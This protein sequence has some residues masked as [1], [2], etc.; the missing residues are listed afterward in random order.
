MKTLKQELKRR[1]F[2][3][4]GK[5]PEAVVISVCSGDAARARAMIEEFRRLVPDRRHFEIGPQEGGVWRIYLKLRRE[6]R[7]YRI[8]Q[9]AVLFDGDG[10]HRPLRIAACLLAPRRI[11]A[12][13]KGL[14]R[15]HPRLSAWIASWLFLRGVPLDRIFL[16]PWWLC[17]WK[18]DRSVVPTDCRILEGRPVSPLRPRVAVL[19]P[20]FPYPL[21]HGGAVRI[22]HLLR[23]AARRFDIF[24]F[25]FTESGQPLETAPVL[26]FCAR[27]ILVPKP[28]YR[29]PRWSSLSPPEVNE[30]RSPVMRRLLAAAR[31]EH[32][33]ALLQ[34]EYTQLA[35]YGGDILVEHDVTFDLYRQLHEQR[36]TLASWWDL[37]RWRRYERRALRRFRRVVVMSGKDAGM[38][39][40]PHVVAIPNGVDLERFRPAP[41]PEAVGLLFIGSFRHFPNVIAYRFFAEE[42]WPLIRDEFPGMTVTVVAGPGLLTF[43]REATGLA[44][45][46]PDP[47]IRMLEFV[48]DVRPLYEEASLVLVPTLVSA[49][50]NVK[51]LEAMAM[52]RAVVSTSSGCAGLGLTHGA[53]VWIA[54]TPEDFAAG[55]RRLIRDPDL[56]RS[57]AKAAR[58]QAEQHFDWRR[59]GAEQRR[60]W[61]EPRPPGVAVRPA[62]IPDLEEIAAIQAAS[63]EAS[64]WR[65][66]SYLEHRCLVALNGGRVAGFVAWREL[67]EGECE[68]LNLAVAPAL[69]RQGLARTLVRQVLAVSEGPVFLEVRKSNRAAV[70][71]YEGLGFQQIGTRPKYYPHPPE[72][73]IV[74][75]FQSC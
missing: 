29:E 9:A 65:P 34:V 37:A 33:I 71:L 23:E 3:L 64:N 59:L 67:G 26:E 45:P 46:S 57:M 73:G 51:V 5:D 24:L 63:P 39:G 8:G 32:A 4:L 16:R 58:R 62:G 40:A 47:R 19:S 17:P 18:R 74:M 10:A 61:A 30:Y 7:A 38:L 42:V 21:S 56:R 36:R 20:Y 49:G 35:S 25:A 12:F 55:I 75:R 6:F 66:E 28:R 41:E 14:E 22:F 69:R 15:H 48:R 11:L 53:S 31:R 43:W 27:V 68:I 60:L 72:D 54:D 50:T 52:E 1:L 70:N 13:N 44:A 2:G